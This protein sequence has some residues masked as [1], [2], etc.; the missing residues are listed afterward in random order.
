MYKTHT[1]NHIVPLEPLLNQRIDS[2][3]SVLP[4]KLKRN[5]KLKW[6]WPIAVN[7]E[8]KC[9]C[10]HCLCFLLSWLKVKNKCCH[11]NFLK[12]IEML[13]A[14]F[15]KRLS[16]KN[17]EVHF[18]GKKEKTGCGSFCCDNYMNVAKSADNPPDSIK[19]STLQ[20]NAQTKEIITE[21]H[22]HTPSLKR[23]KPLTVNVLWKLVL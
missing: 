17:G 18:E 14:I 4:S 1:A 2:A 7:A 12:S 20:K 6:K 16:F 10:I 13:G 9:A 8:H 19:S 3:S 22:R 23:R 5:E 11:S 15:G 21:T